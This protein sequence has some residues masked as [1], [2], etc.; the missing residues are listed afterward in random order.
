MAK[1]EFWIVSTKQPTLAFKI[2]HLDKETMRAKLLG[3]T[4]VPFEQSITDD[5]LKKYGYQITVRQVE[6][7]AVPG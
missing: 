3:P 2:I 6:N 1:K 5:N 4:G 7:A